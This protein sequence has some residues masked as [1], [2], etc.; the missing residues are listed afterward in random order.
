LLSHSRIW[1]EEKAQ[2]RAAEKEAKKKDAN[3]QAKAVKKVKE[4]VEKSTLGDL[5][6]LAALKERMDKDAQ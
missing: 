4:S 3:V 2:E 5:D 6:S 1:E